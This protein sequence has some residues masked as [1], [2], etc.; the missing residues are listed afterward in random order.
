MGPRPAGATVERRNNS[1]DYS[2][3]NCHWASRKAQ[4]RNKR[5]N[6]NLTYKGR[7]QCLTAW[8]EELDMSWATLYYR[9]VTAGWSTKQAM[10]TPV[11]S[12][13]SVV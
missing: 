12:R 6:L 7:T 9:V 11:R 10:E 4:N 3:S 2:P 5:S 1:K 8:A 13:P